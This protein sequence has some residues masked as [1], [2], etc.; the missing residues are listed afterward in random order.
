MW[1][2]ETKEILFYEDIIVHLTSMLL[3]AFNNYIKVFYFFILL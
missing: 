1:M 3:G 2:E